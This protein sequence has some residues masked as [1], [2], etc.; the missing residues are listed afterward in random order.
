MS[1][2]VLKRKPIFEWTKTTRNVKWVDAGPHGERVEKNSVITS[3]RPVAI[4]GIREWDR[5]GVTSIYY[6][7]RKIITRR[8]CSVT[9]S[10]SMFHASSGSLVAW[11]EG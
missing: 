8:K 10:G 7:T 4:I 6:Q 5:Y 3:R 11:C 1:D 2:V 9:S